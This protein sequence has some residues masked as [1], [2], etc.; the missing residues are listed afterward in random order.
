[1]AHNIKPKRV[2]KVVSLEQPK[3][4]KLETIRCFSSSAQCWQ[5]TL[6]YHLLM[7]VNSI[8][9]SS[10]GSCTKALKICISFDPSLPFLREYVLRK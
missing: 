9:G 2:R 4:C 1:M 6:I 3:K 7:Q 10:L 8:S 5:G